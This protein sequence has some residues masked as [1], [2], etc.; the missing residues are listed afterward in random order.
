VWPGLQA[1]IIKKGGIMTRCWNVFAV[2]GISVITAL[3]VQPDQ[4]FF[5]GKLHPCTGDSVWVTETREFTGNGETIKLTVLGM[6]REWPDWNAYYAERSDFIHGAIELAGLQCS[7][8][9][10]VT[11][12]PAAI[13]SVTFKQA[14]FTHTA[15]PRMASLST[16]SQTSGQR[17]VQPVVNQSGGGGT[18]VEKIE[19]QSETETAKAVRL[20]ATAKEAGPRLT[21][22]PNHVTTDLEWDLFKHKGASGNGFFLRAGYS[23]TLSNEKVVIGGTL[24]ANTLLMMSKLYLNNALNLFGTYMLSESA[25]LERKIGGALNVFMV[26]KDLSG[27]PIG[28]SAVANYIDNWFVGEDNILTYGLM[29]QESMFADIK[30]TLL[31][32]GILYGLPLAERF[33]LNVDVIYAANVLTIGKDGAVKPD[34]P[35]M[36]QPALTV[37]TYFT[38]LFSLDLGIKSTFLIEGYND[39][40]VTLGTVILF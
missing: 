33:S 22:P 16:E 28:F 34:N 27:S 39:L 40:I 31:T 2:I 30:T 17:A 10:G 32:A 5:A 13:A 37:S 3:A 20:D 35:M 15:Q 12:I 29:A 26:D 18:P 25:G 21:L 6:S 24:I 9:G 36:L 14:I 8:A 23:R 1:W 4:G 19:A 38:K 7:G 11:S